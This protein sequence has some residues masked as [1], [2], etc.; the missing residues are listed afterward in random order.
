L[1]QPEPADF[2]NVD[3]RMLNWRFMNF[4]VVL[5]ATTTLKQIATMIE[6]RHGKVADLRLFS[7]PPSLQS[8]ITNLA[9]RLEDLGYKGSAPEH[10]E[11]MILFYDY[12]ASVG[13]SL[14]AFSSSNGT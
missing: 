4:S 2:V 11:N 9:L 12:K 8:E 6:A 10:P 13:D 7:S 3:I 14:L 1:S 5:R